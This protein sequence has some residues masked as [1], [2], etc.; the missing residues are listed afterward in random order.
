MHQLL[1]RSLSNSYQ[2]SQDIDMK[3]ISLKENLVYKDLAKGRKDI[4]SYRLSRQTIMCSATV[5]QRL[6]RYFA[7][8]QVYY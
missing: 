6:K 7:I 3:E 8:H 2:S 4:I 5:P 1:S